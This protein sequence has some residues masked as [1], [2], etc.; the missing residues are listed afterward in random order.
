MNDQAAAPQPNR[1]WGNTAE[2][3][4]EQRARISLWSLPRVFPWGRLG[5]GAVERHVS[6]GSIG[7]SVLHPLPVG[8]PVAQSRSDE[9][10]YRAPPR[11]NAGERRLRQASPKELVHIRNLLDRQ[12]A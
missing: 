3:Y 2:D 7:E 4:D 6:R 5:G 11:E 8:T 1:D 9:S 12:L 10:A